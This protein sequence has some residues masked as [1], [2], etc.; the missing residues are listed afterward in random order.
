MGLVAMHIPDGYLGP[1]T[2]VVFWLVMVPI[3][4]IASPLIWPE[5]ASSKA[6]AE[7]LGM[8]AIARASR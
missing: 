1:Q 3:W 7:A 5:I 4:F 6:R 2:Y 8:P